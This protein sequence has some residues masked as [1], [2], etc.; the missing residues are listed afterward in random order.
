MTSHRYRKPG[1][2]PGTTTTPHGKW[3]AKKKAGGWYYAIGSFDT[4]ERAS[5]AVKLFEHWIGCGYAPDS[6][7]RKPTTRDAI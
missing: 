7:P 3:Q 5:V 6:V 4:P 2:I 1:G